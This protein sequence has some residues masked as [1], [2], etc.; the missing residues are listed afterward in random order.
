MARVIT[1]VSEKAASFCFNMIK[2]DKS[3]GLQGIGNTLT[4]DTGK[5]PA[6]T[7]PCSEILLGRASSRS[8]G[9]GRSP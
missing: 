3:L 7:C 6:G 1:K 2:Y 5:P 4:G 8:A 9:C